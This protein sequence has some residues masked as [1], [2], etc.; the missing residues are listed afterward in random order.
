MLGRARATPPAAGRD[1]VGSGIGSE[2][3]LPGD[4]RLRAAHITGRTGATQAEAERRGGPAWAKNGLAA[5]KDGQS[6]MINEI[7]DLSSVM[8]GFRD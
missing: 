6:R 1:G 7:S 2:G 3:A 5:A 8:W 4:R